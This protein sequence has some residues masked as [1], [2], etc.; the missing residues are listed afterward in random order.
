MKQLDRRK[1]IRYVFAAELKNDILNVRFFM[2]ALLI[3]TAALFVL[4][5]WSPYASFCSDRRFPCGGRGSGEG[6]AQQICPV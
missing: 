4:L 5:Q 2:G 3:L 1:R 6:A